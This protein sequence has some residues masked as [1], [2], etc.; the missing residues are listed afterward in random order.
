MHLYNAN[1]W[2]FC[3]S[4]V[5]AAGFVDKPIT[6][7]LGADFNNSSFNDFLGK[8]SRHTRQEFRK[9]L[10]RLEREGNVKLI[11]IQDAVGYLAQVDE[12]RRLYNSRWLDDH[13]L[14]PD[15]KYYQCRHKA[16]T[17]L[18]EAKRMVL[19]LL[20][21]DGQMAAYSLGFIHK[22]IF[23][24]WQVSHDPRFGQFSPG[25]LILGKCIEELISRGF[26]GF[27]FM[28]GDYPY[29]RSW[30]SQDPKSTNYELFAGNGSVH[31]RLYLKYRLQWRDR[32]R[33]YYHNLLKNRCMR[34]LKRWLES[35]KR[36]VRK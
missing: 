3:W 8:L 20:N 6:D 22:Q 17:S 10:R 34:M 18:F 28:A 16:V 26:T 23:Y 36:A 21:V 32:L 1:D 30:S 7:I 24:D 2:S 35:L 15:D 33:E 14:P 11:C 29:K 19:F 13:R 27:N 9:K 31:A 4:P 25:I 12:M 5:K